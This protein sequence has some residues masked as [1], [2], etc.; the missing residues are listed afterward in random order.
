MTNAH[1]IKLGTRQGRLERFLHVRRRH[2]GGEFPGQDVAGVVV[3][4]GG[5][6]IPAPALD[7]EVGEVGL[8]QLV[9]PAGG[10]GRTCRRR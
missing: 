9:H 10:G 7:L 6:V 8:P 2:R 4:H 5:R 3:Q 1:S